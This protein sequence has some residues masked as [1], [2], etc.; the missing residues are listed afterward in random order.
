MPSFSLSLL[1]QQPT[2]RESRRDHYY[3]SDIS[4]LYFHYEP[5]ISIFAP[6]LLAAVY[7]DMK[8]T[9]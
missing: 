2:D 6:R 4:H 5:K 8:L 9:S 1:H 7:C 3:Q